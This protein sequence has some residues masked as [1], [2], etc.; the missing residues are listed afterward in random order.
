ML[1]LMLIDSRPT[2][3]FGKQLSAKHSGELYP[4]GHCNHDRTYVGFD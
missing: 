2:F 4:N 1:S 3:A